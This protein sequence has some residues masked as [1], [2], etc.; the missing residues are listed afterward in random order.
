MGGQYKQ[1]PRTPIRG[2]VPRFA[3]WIPACAGID[4]QFTKS[5]HYPLPILLDRATTGRYA[6]IRL[7]SG[8]ITPRGFSRFV[9]VG[10]ENSC[11]RRIQPYSIPHKIGGGLTACRLS[12]DNHIP[13][14]TFP[15]CICLKQITTYERSTSFWNSK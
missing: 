6:P 13:S 5:R 1:S 8:S 11:R 15:P 10:R 4:A 7:K 2:P 3:G 14:A 12:E 9:S